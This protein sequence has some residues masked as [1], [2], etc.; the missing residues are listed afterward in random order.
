MHDYTRSILTT[1]IYIY[2]ISTYLYLGNVVFEAG[3]GASADPH[4]TVRFDVPSN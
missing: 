1:Y 2:Y 3:P 4:G